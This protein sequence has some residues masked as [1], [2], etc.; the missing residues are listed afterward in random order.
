MT[1]RIL[2]TASLFLLTLALAPSPASALPP[3]PS[4]TCGGGATGGDPCTDKVTTAQQKWDNVYWAG[5]DKIDAGRE[6]QSCQLECSLNVLPEPEESWCRNTYCDIEI[7]VYNEAVTALGTALS[8]WHS[9]TLA[10][11]QCIQNC[12][13][14]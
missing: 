10:V 13:Q 1:S 4:N 11:T 7:D 8:T 12:S 2:F 9:A 3:D 6:L 14:N 5:Q